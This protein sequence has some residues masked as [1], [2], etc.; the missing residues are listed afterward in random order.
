M[1]SSTN[2]SFPQTLQQRLSK[3]RSIEIRKIRSIQSL[4][5]NRASQSNFQLSPVFVFKNNSYHVASRTISNE[6]PPLLNYEFKTTH[7]WI[8]LRGWAWKE[9]VEWTYG[10]VVERGTRHGDR[11]ERGRRGLRTSC[12]LDVAGDCWVRGCGCCCGCG[13]WTIHVDGARR[14]GRR[15]WPALWPTMSTGRVRR[16]RRKSG[17]R[18]GRLVVV[19]H[20]NERVPVTFLTHSLCVATAGIVSSYPR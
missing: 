11:R 17:L 18:C 8:T 15:K 16:R 10:T 9:V 2:L 20:C 19:H 12:G 1:P 3:L 13:A 5:F 14:V 6:R 7:H 4:L